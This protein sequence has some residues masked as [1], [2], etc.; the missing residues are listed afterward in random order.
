MTHYLHKQQVR[1]G[2]LLEELF[3]PPKIESVAEGEDKPMP[4]LPF[5]NTLNIGDVVELN[6]MNDE[7]AEV[8]EA[9]TERSAIGV[10]VPI[11]TLPVL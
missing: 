11:P 3:V 5:A 4:T 2:R 6:A 8:D 10:V 1:I 7:V 9:M